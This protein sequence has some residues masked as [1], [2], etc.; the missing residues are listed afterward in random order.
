VAENRLSI[1]PGGARE[2]GGATSW[3]PRVVTTRPRVEGK[4]L[5][6]GA[7]KF[8]LHGVTYGTFAPGPDGDGYPPAQVVA[9]DF[10]AMA[11]AGLN[12]VRVYTV[13]PRILLDLAAEHGLAV[14]VGL[15]W[16]QHVAFL[17]ER[18]RRNDIERRV[19]EGV[20]ACAGHPAVLG[21]AVGN[22]I[23]AG[24]VRWHG[25][26]RVER[27]L[28]RLVA[29]ARDEDPDALVTY[30]NY[31]STEYLEVPNVD[32]ACFNVY[33]ERRDRLAA[34][35]ARL[36]N[37]AGDLPLVMAEIGLDSRRN[38]TQAQADVLAWQLRT[39]RDAGAAGTFVFSWTDEW[40]RGGHDIDDWDF[41]LTDRARRPKPALAAV[42]ATA[43]EPAFADRAGWPRISVVVCTYNGAA[44][45]DECLTAARALDYPDYEIVVVSDGS[46]DATPDIARAHGVR[47]VETPNR[48]LSSA[49]NT[50]LDAATGEI[51]AYLDDDARPDAA[52]LRHVAAAMH[53]GDCAAVGGPNIAPPG[54]GWVAECVAR[55]PGGP[56][57]VLLSDRDA[58][59][60]PG[61]NLA[62]RKADLEAIGGFDPRFRAA[63]DDVDV[64]W[65]LLD[66]GGRLGFTPGAV[67]LHHRRGTVRAY[68]RQQRGYGAA[69][70]LLERKWPE[71]YNAAGHVPWAGRVYGEGARGRA[72]ARR[73]R[74][75][76]GVWG[77]AFFQAIYQPQP[78]VLA[79]LPGMPEW[80]LLIAALTATSAL[81]ALFHPFLLALPLLAV[82]LGAA[83]ADAAAAA[84]R[85]CAP[86]RGRGRRR[87]R[88]RTLALTLALHLLQ[89]GAR[90]AG[91][92]GMGLTLWR[93]RGT[94]GVHLP[95]PRERSTW[96][97]RW[98]SVEDRLA[99]IETTLNDDGA[100]TR[101]GGPYD[102]WDLQIRGGIIADARV[103]VA[104]E[105]HGAGRQLVRIRLWPRWRPAAL[106]AVLAPFAPAAAALA[107]GFTGPGAILLA[108]GAVLVAT[109]LHEAALAVG[110]AARACAPERAP[111]LAR[112]R[113]EPTRGHSRPPAPAHERAIP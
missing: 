106:A 86:V 17:N 14:L 9:R 60:L 91:R 73:G 28:Q 107:A 18:T 21:Y 76:F 96:S 103:R 99:D 46:T 38:G 110:A 111:S 88:A 84:R 94:S 108:L 50:G 5:F 43:A 40:H 15:P 31:P 35:L 65:R 79:A 45:L 101:R 6:R 51:V 78:T 77:S 33:L 47:L 59:H 92:L 89:P 68:L 95:R 13:P 22:E 69:E 57:H 42:A 83:V 56:S 53:D 20:R 81:G 104:V 55:S 102:R 27:Y 74:V 4:F 100:V 26:A 58:E 54:D 39:A 11:A 36:Q 16:E 113:R 7:E 87:D 19:R 25:R 41:G 29:A 72:A 32:F 112:E 10:G 48:G 8:Y 67:V 93:R 37:L 71:R 30:V 2:D 44:T 24:I 64:C 34:Y 61:C 90:L 82:V 85:A 97:E 70:A 12:A 109:A 23:P 66:R 62:I 1:A 52:W 3:H 49:R 80:Y 63:G 105:E 75:Y 98:R